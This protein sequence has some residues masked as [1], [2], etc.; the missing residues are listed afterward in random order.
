[1]ECT[2]KRLKRLRGGTHW[3]FISN[4]SGF[5]KNSLGKGVNSVTDPKEYVRRPHISN[6]LKAL[7]LIFALSIVGLAIN[8]AIGSF[9]PFWLLLGFSIFY[10]IEK[11]F[12]Y[13]T[14]RHKGLGK[15]YRLLLNLSILSLLGLLVWLGIKVFSQQ[16]MQSP[17]VGS[18]IFI[19]GLV[20]FIW[21]CRVVAKI[22][23]DGQV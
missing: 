15:L 2:N 10:S 23:A 12:Y 8:I 3:N 14:R 19:A 21:M 18:L 11:W 7:L 4:Q 22:A 6:W 17:I 9:I 16:L 20:L 13:L 1:V 5:G